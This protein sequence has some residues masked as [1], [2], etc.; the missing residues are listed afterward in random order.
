MEQNT[1][2]PAEPKSEETVVPQPSA[3][4]SEILHL[5]GMLKHVQA[6]FENYKKRVERDRKQSV[7]QAGRSL[8]EQ[9]IPI[10]DIFDLALSGAEDNE[11]TRGFKMVHDQFIEVLKSQGVEVIDQ[12]NVSLNPQVH[13]V[14]GES[15]KGGNP[16]KIAEVIKKGYKL[17]DRVIRA[18]TVK[19]FMFKGCGSAQMRA[20]EMK[21]KIAEWEAKKKQAEQEAK[22]S[23]L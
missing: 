17:H 23:P 5:T 2:T 7:E 22:K 11:T 4:E 18:A 10:L 16:H 3:E 15:F 19:T 8:I 21:E 13:E 6:E 9:L 12:V 20:A 14:I 1:K